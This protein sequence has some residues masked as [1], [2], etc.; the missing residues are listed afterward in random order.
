MN[1]YS[2]ILLQAAVKK[3]DD[4]QKYIKHLSFILIF[5]LLLQNEWTLN[6]IIFHISL[7]LCL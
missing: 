7:V 3:P 6:A 5:N 1:H 2:I 4:F